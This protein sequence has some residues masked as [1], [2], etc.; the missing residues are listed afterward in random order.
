MR[1]AVPPA[2]T[3][4]IVLVDDHKMLVLGLRTLFH[5]RPDV[6][7][8]GIAH[9]AGEAIAVCRAKRPKVAVL[10]LTLE[11]DEDGLELCRWLRTELPDVEI[12]FYT[13][14]DDLGVA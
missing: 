9:D 6:E 2:L 12:V 4:P 1:L 13:G 10:D 14:A 3:V 8:V 7:V 5:S 11:G